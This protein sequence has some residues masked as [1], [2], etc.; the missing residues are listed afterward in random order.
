[1]LD[2]V[3]EELWKSW[4]PEHKPGT[5]GNIGSAVKQHAKT[6][7]HNIHPNYVSILETGMKA[8]NK[9]LFLELLHSFLD[10]N[11]VNERAPFPRVY[12][13]LVS[14]LWSNEQ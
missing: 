2:R 12:A 7:C 11:S 10:R 8:K 14:S 1:M 5:N 9:T 3:K 13:S 4:G 6:T